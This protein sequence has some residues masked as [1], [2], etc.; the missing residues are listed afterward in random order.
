[1]K[2]NNPSD[3]IPEMDQQTLRVCRLVSIVHFFAYIAILLIILWN[4]GL[5][6]L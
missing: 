3:V 1:M 5:I 2:S 6:E 4:L